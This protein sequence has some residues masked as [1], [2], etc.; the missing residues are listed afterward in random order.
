ML[1][2]MDLI[3]ILIWQTSEKEHLWND[4]DCMN[5]HWILMIL[6]IVNFVRHNYG[7]VI[8]P[9]NN[10][11]FFK[12]FIFRNHNL[13]MKWICLAHKFDLKIMVVMIAKYG[14]KCVMDI[15]I[16]IMFFFYVCLCFFILKKER[17]RK[18]FIIYNLKVISHITNRTH[19]ILRKTLV[20]RIMGWDDFVKLH[21]LKSQTLLRTWWNDGF[22]SRKM[23]I[24]TNFGVNT[25][26]M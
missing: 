16:F 12:G 8:M 24:Y 3:C 13:W 22:L 10:F 1:Q 20:C 11:Y 7:V 19:T 15:Q 5:I 17:E 26:I 21:S 4:W 6:N 2:W 14:W 9:E 23:Y 25:S 18:M